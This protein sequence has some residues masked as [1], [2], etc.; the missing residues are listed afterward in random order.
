M[1]IET[2]RTKPVRVESQLEVP[3]GVDTLDDES[4]NQLYQLIEAFLTLNPSP[5]D[6]QV[7]ALST[8]LG[9]DHKLFE[10]VIYR[11][12][13]EIITA[14]SSI[15]ASDPDGALAEHDGDLDLEP[16]GQPDVLKEAG[17]ADG[18]VDTE[19]LDSKQ[20]T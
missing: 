19:L 9:M 12:L 3:S 10:A 13:S 11:I 17:E 14:S 2:V 6:E 8:S 4:R 18:G 16:L 20:G 7:H 15:R 5:T 1:P